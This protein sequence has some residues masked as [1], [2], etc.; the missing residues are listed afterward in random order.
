[1]TTVEKLLVNL[2]EHLEEVDRDTVKRIIGD[3]TENNRN[4]TINQLVR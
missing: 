2:E 3:S 1:M 4:L